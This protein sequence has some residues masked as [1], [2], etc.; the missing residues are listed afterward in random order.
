MLLL[1]NGGRPSESPLLAGD[2]VSLCFTCSTAKPFISGLKVKLWV[3]SVRLFFSVN[4][5]CAK[6]ANQAVGWAVEAAQQKLSVHH[7]TT[8]WMWM[9][10]CWRS[11]SSSCGSESSPKS[12]SGC[13][14]RRM[15]QRHSERLNL[16]P[17]FCSSPKKG[18]LKPFSD[19]GCPTFLQT[20]LLI[21]FE[22]APQNIY[23]KNK[24]SIK[25]KKFF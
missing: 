4:P 22:F 24:F 3:L 7:T 12:F 9:S 13:C 14:W 11:T 10:T 17:L 21:G 23:K 18:G 1:K 20:K 15:L 8:T 5:L 2:S 6:L 16:Q 25:F 19:A